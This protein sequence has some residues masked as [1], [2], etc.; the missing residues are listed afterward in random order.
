MVPEWSALAYAFSGFILVL[1][2]R[3]GSLR[4]LFVLYGD[5]RLAD[6]QIGDA[7]ADEKHNLRWPS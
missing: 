3:R 4:Q 7:V 2:C 6:L 5:R 1:R